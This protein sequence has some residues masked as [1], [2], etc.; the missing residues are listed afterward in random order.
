M[1]S[2][3]NWGFGNL[4]SHHSHP[5]PSR[6]IP[7]HPGPS[8][9]G[10]SLGTCSTTLW[11]IRQWLSMMRFCTVCSSEWTSAQPGS[12]KVSDADSAI[13]SCVLGIFHKG[14]MLAMFGSFTCL[15]NEPFKPRLPPQIGIVKPKQAH[16]G[17]VPTIITY[18][19]LPSPIIHWILG[20][21]LCDS[22]RFRRC[23]RWKTSPWPG[24]PRSKLHKWDPHGT[25]CS[26]AHRGTRPGVL[27]EVQRRGKN[28]GTQSLR[29][30]KHQ[31][32]HNWKE[33]DIVRYSR[34][35]WEVVSSVIRNFAAG[36]V[37]FMRSE[38]RPGRFRH[39]SDITWPITII[40]VQ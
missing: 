23:H 10:T 6:A 15:R 36:P 17:M 22:S 4:N 18:H 19:H 27:S 5:R 24:H 8:E 25:R 21:S 14:E 9:E 39:E 26:A 20:L 38:M 40:I 11:R 33:L 7:G 34:C 1:I 37:S 28:H 12:V 2:H 29:E 30:K 3:Q 13:Q 16:G 32:E 35:I 31:M